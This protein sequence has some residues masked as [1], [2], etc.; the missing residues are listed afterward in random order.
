MP[1]KLL[2]VCLPWLKLAGF[3]LK[4]AVYNHTIVA[5]SVVLDISLLCLAIIEVRINFSVENL[6][7]ASEG[8]T[9]LLQVG[10][11]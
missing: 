1:T 7:S 9:G 2:F 6:A 8:I 3:D 11:L 5:V 4:N 10:M